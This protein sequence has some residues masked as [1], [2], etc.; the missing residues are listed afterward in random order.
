MMASSFASTYQ[1]LLLAAGLY[2]RCV[3]RE[4]RR[5]GT[6]AQEYSHSREMSTNEGNP[7]H[8]PSVVVPPLLPPGLNRNAHGHNMEHSSRR[9]LDGAMSPSSEVAFDKVM[10]HIASKVWSDEKDAELLKELE[11]VLDTD[12]YNAIRTPFQSDVAT[13]TTAVNKVMSSSIQTTHHNIDG[14]IVPD[15]NIVVEDEGNDSDNEDIKFDFWG[16]P[17]QKQL[18][19]KSANVPVSG[20]RA[21]MLVSLHR[22]VEQ[23]EEDTKPSSSGAGR[24]KGSADDSGNCDEESEDEWD[25]DNDDGYIA[26]TMSLKEFL[27]MET[28]N[29]EDLK[30]HS[31]D[32]RPSSVWI[33]A[34]EQGVRRLVF[35]LSDLKKVLLKTT[36]KII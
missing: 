13:T 21:A 33:Q 32:I 8:P 1:G 22:E 26:V 31:D 11:S 25:D 28:S 30:E 18:L 14:K 3:S 12:T 24:N 36:Q 7:Y 17:F 34:R 23:E 10:R 19:S 2:L 20:S 35:L 4:D 9:N 16:E 29:M 5:Q 6:P 27:I 15:E